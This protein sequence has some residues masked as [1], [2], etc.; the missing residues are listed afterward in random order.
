MPPRVKV[1]VTGM[2]T[3][4]SKLIQAKEEAV[5]AAMNAA[6]EAVE[7]IKEE[8]ISRAPVDTGDLERCHATS[9]KYFKSLGK[10]VGRVYLDDSKAT[11]L[12]YSPTTKYA[13]IMHEHLAPYGSGAFNLGEGSLKKSAAG[14]DVGGKFLLRAVEDNRKELSDALQRGVMGVLERR[15][16]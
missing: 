14:H 15:L 16:Q 7:L 12:H 9:V 6:N 1:K 5:G 13:T 4:L 2:G 8:S 11:H 10:V 3:L